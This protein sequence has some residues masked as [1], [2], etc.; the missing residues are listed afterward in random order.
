MA[1]SRRGASLIVLFL[2]VTIGAILYGAHWLLTTSQSRM[3]NETGQAL[4]NAATQQTALLTVWYGALTNQ[5]KAFV[6]VDMLRLFA[7]EID[8]ADADATALL[9]VVRPSLD[10]EE[11]NEQQ[12]KDRKS[13]D[14]FVD[15]MPGL[16]QLLHEFVKKNSFLDAYVLNRHLTPFLMTAI[17]YPFDEKNHPLLEEVVKSGTPRLLPI[18]KENR[19]LVVDMVFPIFAPQYIDH[20]G[21]HVVALFIG[22]CSVQ[23][24]ISAIDHIDNEGFFTSAVLESQNGTLKIIDPLYPGGHR[25]L[26]EGWKLQN[27]ALPLAVRNEPTR[28]EKTLPAYTLAHEVPDL[29]WLVMRGIRVSEAEASYLRLKKNVY[30]GVALLI[31]LAVILITALWWW[32][33]GRRERAHA[34]QMRKLYSLANEQKQ[35]LDSVNSALSAGI[36]LND[37]SGK[38]Y[39]VNQKYADMAHMAPER[40]F[41]MNHTQL[42]FD[43]AHSLVTHTIQINAKPVLTN[44]TEILPVGE[45]K[46]HF[47][48]ACSPC[49]DENCYLTGMVS[50]YSDITELVE[51]Q[52]RAQ[53][54]VTQ[55]VEV[56][57]RAMEAVDPYLRGQSKSTASLAAHLAKNLAHDDEETLSTLRIA[58]NLSQIGMIQLPKSLLLKT[59]SLSPEE[60]L[61]MQEHVEYAKTSLE[62]VDFG[63]P[64]L[65]A[66][67]EM[68]ERI[69]GS[70]Y[71]A[72]L[73]GDE[74]CF[75][76]RVLAVANT[77]CAL[78]RPRSYRTAHTTE[79]ALKIFLTKPY[80]YDL[81]IVEALRR[82]LETETG[83]A[84]LEDLVGKKQDKIL[85]EANSLGDD[86]I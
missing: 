18:R 75:N 62:G 83:R 77:F 52:E 37:L 61:Q 48:T 50:V 26:D 46:R 47:L 35:I 57:V 11:D 7:S 74:I 42:P 13:I 72:H 12:P 81:S 45:S 56:L 32:V 79:S 58:A 55:T 2:S 8:S 80:K 29:P 9:E 44:F 36:V 63:L 31:A 71:P 15:R 65:E 66:I 43:L 1:K 5:V 4:H 19:E 41:G 14:L 54:M 34:D 20:K 3:L 24:V 23:K 85:K 6:D 10:A 60:R 59:G 21:N 49:I 51:A 64:V 27:G 73:K 22:T 30:I 76:A 82:F 40:M 38:I 25:N 28:M 39:Y 67:T 33:V 84:F 68:Y 70:G 86:S 69:D 16:A 53:H 17:K 78:M